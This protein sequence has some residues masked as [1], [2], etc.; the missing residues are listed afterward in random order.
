LPGVP[1]YHTR[2]MSQDWS[3]RRDIDLLAD[4]RVCVEF[5]IP[6]AEFPRL[7]SQLAHAA[8]SASGR[9]C[10]ERV[11]GACVAEITLSA[12]ASL[13]CQRCLR[14]VECPI[15]CAGRVAMVADGAEADRAP[16]GLETILAPDR[17]MSVRDLVEEELFLA[18]PIVPL[19]ENPEC[20]RAPGARAGGPA[21]GGQR[22]FER[23]SE[24]LKRGQ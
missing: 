5:D 11:Q 15:D 24:L 17:R 23:L 2:P 13:T 7:R 14:P 9:V 18:L 20:A 4:E 3:R 12:R 22:P 8:G 6:L 10:F 21:P 1:T 19:H 16:Q